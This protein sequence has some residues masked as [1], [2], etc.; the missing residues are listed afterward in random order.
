MKWNGM[1]RNAME[2]NEME[3]RTT[4][5]NLKVHAP[6]PYKTNRNSKRVTSIISDDSEKIIKLCYKMTKKIIQKQSR[7]TL[8][9]SCKQSNNIARSCATVFSLNL[10][11]NI[12][13][14]PLSKE[15][16]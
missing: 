15:K 9:N 3:C 7:K 14:L 11:L 4:E 10:F 16:S 13:L 6:A 5:N 2:L 12:F 8:N 1:K